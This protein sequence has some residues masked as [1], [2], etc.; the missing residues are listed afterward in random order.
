MAKKNIAEI[1]KN[2]AVT[3]VIPEG[4]RLHNVL[5]AP[6]EI[7]GL[8]EPNKTGRFERMPLF[9]QQDET[10]NEGARRLMT[11]TAGGR[12]RFMTDSKVIAIKVDL[13]SRTVFSHMPATGVC[14]FDM[15]TQTEDGGYRYAKTFVPPQ[16]TS[17]TEYES[18][19][20]FEDNR[21]RMITIH[22]PLYNDV[23]ELYIGLEENAQLLPGK[24]YAVEKPVVFYGSSVTQGGCASR[25]GMCHTN[26]LTRM[27]DCDTV[28]LGFSGSDKG[29]PAMAEYM[30][31]LPMSVF[32]YGYGYN[33]PSLD[34]YAKTYYPFYRIIRD[35]NP[36]LPIVMMSN[37]VSI[38]AKEPN[39]AEY[40]VRRR[41]ITMQAFVD[42]L[43][44]GDKNL[45]FVDGAS[46]LGGILEAEDA[47]VDGT[48]PTD[49]GFLNMAKY[50]YPLLRRLLHND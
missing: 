21:M 2:L 32:V 18:V 40:L 14:G 43:A 5:E 1:D 24:K 8:C 33:A 38:T 42:G 9:M 17:V 31:T 13:G 39:R 44:E 19:H 20:T 49:L 11:N 47:T 6:F 36:D 22:F 45:Y 12:I 30:K 7:Y 37:P 10:V 25:P 50:M 16:D 35:R 41:E 23:Q 4:V 27:L 46:S 15:Y 48:H 3:S 34:H 26:I 28:N 29:E